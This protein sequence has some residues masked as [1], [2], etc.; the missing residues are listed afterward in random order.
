MFSIKANIDTNITTEQAANTI[1]SKLK[2]T[3][4]IWS[5]NLI[6]LYSHSNPLRGVINMPFP[7][8]DPFKNHLSISIEEKNNFS[9]LR[10]KLNFGILIFLSLLIFPAV[11]L[12]TSNGLQNVDLV[13][14]GIGFIFSLFLYI[15]FRFKLSW[16]YNRVLK[17]VA[18]ECKIN[19]LNK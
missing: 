16:D 15:V 17:W 3:K 19:R 7:I 4:G 8:S 13:S 14:L 18:E 2:P 5:R 1:M 12:S 9:T 11:V 10:I 6:S